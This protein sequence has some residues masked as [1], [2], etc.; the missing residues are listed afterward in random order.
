MLLLE[1]ACV[2]PNEAGH[3]ARML[4]LGAA[5]TSGALRSRTCAR[6]HDNALA[7]LSFGASHANAG[8]A[9]MR[10]EDWQVH[11]ARNLRTRCSRSAIAA[12]CS[13]SRALYTSVVGRLRA[14]ASSGSSAV[15]FF[16][17]S[18]K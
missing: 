6:N 7:V 14:A 17:N 1:P 4:A 2:A 8:A 16:R 12:L 3:R 13:V 10:V 15:V 11:L 18:A 9:L 5:D